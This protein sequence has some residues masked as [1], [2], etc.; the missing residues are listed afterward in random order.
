MQPDVIYDMVA[1]WSRMLSA[2][3]MLKIATDPTAV[4]N[5]NTK[6]S[7]TG[8]LAENDLLTLD[9]KL[10]TAEFLDV[11]A[12]TRT[13]VIGSLTGTIPVLTPGRRRTASDRTQTVIFSKTEAAEMEI[14]YIRRYL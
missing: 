11:S 7:Y 6:V 1:G 4:A 14:R 12:G 8:E 5:L 3:E 13:N 9:S 10:K 2:D